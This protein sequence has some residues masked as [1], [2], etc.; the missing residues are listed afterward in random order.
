MTKEA[1]ASDADVGK[2]DVL[3]LFV[4]IDWVVVVV[5]VDVPEVV[6]C[7]AGVDDEHATLAWMRLAEFPVPLL[8]IGL[9]SLAL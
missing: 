5:V 9:Q 1:I 4:T 8:G 7:D 3:M 2:M 6:V